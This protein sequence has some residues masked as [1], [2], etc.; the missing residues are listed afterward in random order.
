MGAIGITKT[1]SVAKI[2]ADLG[3][4]ESVFSDVYNEVGN[5]WDSFADKTAIYPRLQYA[6]AR[7]DSADMLLGELR[8][9]V[10]ATRLGSEV[11]LNELFTNAV[12]IR[13]LDDDWITDIEQ[14]ASAV[15]KPATGLIN[16]RSARRVQP[17]CPNPSDPGYRGDPQRNTWP[18]ETFG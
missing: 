13:K 18:P 3:V 4:S 14:K 6:Y 2:Q 9:N 5:I 10:D 12:K 17:F 8:A 15:M 1:A 7:R 16:K 11:K